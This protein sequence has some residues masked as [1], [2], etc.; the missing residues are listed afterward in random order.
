MRTGT[1]FGRG[2]RGSAPSRQWTEISTTWAIG[3]AATTTTAVL[4]GLQSPAAQAGLNALPPADVVI[5]RIRGDFSV[6]MSATSANWT[7]G[8]TVQDQTWTPAATFALDADKRWLWTR[9]FNTAGLT[10]P[11]TWAEPGW[12]VASS[13]PQTTWSD[14]RWTEVDVAPKVKLESGQGLY[15]VAYEN[16]GASTLS[17]LSTDMRMLWQQ[18]RA[19]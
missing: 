1:R 10:A 6:T 9:T 11:V 12:M 5:M 4:W 19:A 15:L 2:R 8:L 14:A 18:K 3:A 7:L 16:S 17:S 13:D